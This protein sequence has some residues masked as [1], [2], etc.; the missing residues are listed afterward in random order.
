MEPTLW[1]DMTP[2]QFDT[3]APDVQL[4]LFAAGQSGELA[5]LFDATD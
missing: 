3:Q 4:S 5:G 1:L 2:K